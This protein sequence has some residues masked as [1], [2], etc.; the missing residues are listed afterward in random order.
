M[1]TPLGWLSWIFLQ[2]LTLVLSFP[3]RFTSLRPSTPE[4]NQQLSHSRYS[5]K[6]KGDED[7]SYTIA[8]LQGWVYFKASL[9]LLL[10]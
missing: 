10:Q 7:D 5:R 2:R 9:N 3:E 8:S 6:A 1:N 4:N